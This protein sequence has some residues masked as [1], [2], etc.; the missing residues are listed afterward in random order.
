M[1]TLPIAGVVLGHG[2]TPDLK[3]GLVYLYQQDLIVTGNF[4]NVTL[5]LYLN[6]YRAHLNLIYLVLKRIDVYRKQPRMVDKQKYVNWQELKYVQTI[7]EQLNLEL[8]DLENLLPVNRRKRGILNLGCDVLNF[9]FGTATRA[10]LQTLHEAV[11]VI[12]KRQGTMTHSIEH[13]LTYTKELGDNVRQN[14]RDV[15]LLG[16]T[17]KAIVLEVAN[18]NETVE[19]LESNVFTRV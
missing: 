6:W 9:L 8:E 11:G 16:R 5:N 2:H 13:Q 3:K 19:H 18:L 17:L 1:L 10:E 15:S 7:W 14:T 12:K 4:W